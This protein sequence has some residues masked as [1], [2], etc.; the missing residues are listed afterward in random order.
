MSIAFTLNIEADILSVNPFVVSISSDLNDPEWD[1]Y[2]EEC[3]NGYHIQSSY[4]AQ[5]KSKH[6]YNIKRII[7]K[8]DDQIVAGAQ[9][10]YH[11]LSILGHIGYLTR[12]PVLGETDPDPE[13]INLLFDSIK[14]TVIKYKIICLVLQPGKS[15]ITLDSKV[16]KDAIKSISLSTAPR[17]TVLVDLTKT[18]ADILRS[19]R[20]KT[21]QNIRVGIKK[22]VKV[23]VGCADDLNTFYG[24]YKAGS[25]RNNFTPF[26]KDYLF[27]L[28]NILNAREMIKIFIAEYN[29]QAVSALI[30]FLFRDTVYACLTGW[31]GEHKNLQPNEA[32][33]WHAIL[34]A[35]SNGYRYYD[36][37]GIEI[38][39]ARAKLDGETIPESLKKTPTFYKMGFGENIHI[40]PQNYVY[41]YNPI[42][43]Y[44]YRLVDSNILSR[45][46]MERLLRNIRANMSN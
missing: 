34:W 26:S 30:V 2:I 6:G 38:A 13:I 25:E 37:C 27:N 9:I 12:G 21:R 29:D 4:W 15:N 16:Q 31:S 32:L 24:L 17:A 18:T 22:G 20:K 39:A 33:E 42:F 1:N 7:V 5:L 8:R 44:V 3:P 41:I 14:Q 35:H 40:Y 46:Y 45:K 23:R 19:M 36:L 10:L 11:K 28:W 43:R